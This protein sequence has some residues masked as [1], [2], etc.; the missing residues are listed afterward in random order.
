MNRNT[1]VVLSA[2]G[3]VLLVL[4]AWCLTLVSTSR[5]VPPFATAEAIERDYEPQ[6]RRLLQLAQNEQL[7]R[8]TVFND[9]ADV[10]LFDAPEILEAKV[11]P[12]HHLLGSKEYDFESR[13]SVLPRRPSVGD[14]VVN[15]HWDTLRDGSKLTVLEYHG[16]T[17]D[18]QGSEAGLILLLDFSALERKAAKRALDDSL[19]TD[20]AKPGR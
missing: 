4:L 15:R 10:A 2:A 9:P 17:R 5:S 19:Q 11:E 1:V 20:A 14:A 3:I 7:A 13:F 12:S 8:A 16:R 18:G 6:I